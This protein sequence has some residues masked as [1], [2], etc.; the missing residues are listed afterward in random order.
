MENT[1]N[2]FIYERKSAI[3]LRIP[4]IN[5]PIPTIYGGSSIFKI[6]LKNSLI[7]ENRNVVSDKYGRSPIFD[8]FK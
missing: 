1:L 8:I 2:N 7:I 6:C 3:L 4:T 5:L